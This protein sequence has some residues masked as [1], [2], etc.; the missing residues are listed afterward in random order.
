MVIFCGLFD[1]KLY[2]KLNDKKYIKTI[3]T[4]KFSNFIL[5]FYISSSRELLTKFEFHESNVCAV[6]TL[7]FY[8]LLCV[9]KANA[10]F[11]I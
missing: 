7:Q 2:A 6:D 5:C 11:S 10:I 3:L 8:A 4:G 9:D 1:L